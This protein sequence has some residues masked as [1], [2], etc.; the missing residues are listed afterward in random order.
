MTGCEIAS[1]RLRRFDQAMRQC[2]QHHCRFGS[3]DEL[4]HSSLQ[5]YPGRYRAHQSRNKRQDTFVVLYRENRRDFVLLCKAFRSGE[6]DIVRYRSVFVATCT[7]D[8]YKLVSRRVH[9]LR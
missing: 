3:F 4:D 6:W 2:G 7:I 9:T 8:T 1:S 5:D